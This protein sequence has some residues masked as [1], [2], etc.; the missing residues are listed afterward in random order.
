MSTPPRSA[1]PTTPSP[2][3]ASP[4]GT[5]PSPTAALSPARPTISVVR[6]WIT[7]RSLML[8][9]AFLVIATGCFIAAWWQVHR[10]MAG[11]TLSYLYSVEWPAFVVVGGIGGGRMFHDTPEDIAARK[12]HHARR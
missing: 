12:A 1:S 8:H 7:P 3:S 9:V 11:N 6:Q 10:A 5:G 2:K 4:G